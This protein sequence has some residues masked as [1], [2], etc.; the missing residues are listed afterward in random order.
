MR[1]TPAPVHPITSIVRRL[2]ALVWATAHVLAWVCVGLV[3][4]AGVVR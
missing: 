3:V 1:Y 4:V 2:D